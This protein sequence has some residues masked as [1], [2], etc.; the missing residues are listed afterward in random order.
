M[1]RVGRRLGI[2]LYYQVEEIIRNKIE[3]GTFSEG[4]MIPPESEL[5]KEFQ[6]SRITIRKA[7]DNLVQDGLLVKQQGIGTI[8]TKNYIND[9]VNSLEGFTEK[10]EKMGRKVTST[11]LDVQLVVPPEAIATL[12]QVKTGEKVLRISRI[13][14]V[15]G[16]PLAL[17]N[18]YLPLYLGIREDEDFSQSLFDVYS[19]HGIEPAYSD[20]TIH[21]IIADKK[22]AGL[23]HINEGG[24]ALQ[25]NYHT[26]SEDGVPIEYAEGIYRGDWYHYKMR[27]YRAPRH[28]STNRLV[29]SHATDNN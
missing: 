11:M 24:A 20:R 1:D 13:R 6:V 4:Q 25:M 23:L 7:V 15:D 14:N 18:T 21:A 29:I 9:D 2:P 19:R 5:E 26:F 17:F 8:V 10:M 28:P 3:N 22:T 27:I 16:S 12:L